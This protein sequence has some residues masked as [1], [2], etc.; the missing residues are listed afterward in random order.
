MFTHSSRLL[1]VGVIVLLM[2]SPACKKENTNPIPDAYVSLYLNISST[3]Y[4]ELSSVGGWVNLTGGY[5]GLTVYRASADEFMVFERACPFDWEET[6]AFVTVDTSGL[7][8]RCAHCGSEYLILDGSVFKG[9]SNLPLKQYRTT[10]DGMT[11]HIF[12]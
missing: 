6:S 12:N 1:L 3:L 11:L 4:I 8:L 2:V 10:F 5:R 7:L 9:P